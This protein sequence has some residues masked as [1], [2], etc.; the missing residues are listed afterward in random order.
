MM[1]VK[2][3]GFANISEIIFRRVVDGFVEIDM[4]VVDVVDLT[5]GPYKMFFK[6]QCS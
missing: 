4:V 5:N 1:L 6:A 2:V 3:G